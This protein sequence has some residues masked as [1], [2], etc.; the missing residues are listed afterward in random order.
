[1]PK[2]TE[3]MG[4]T[5]R[6]R[7]LLVDGQDAAHRYKAA[8]LEASGHE[9]GTALNGRSAIIA[10]QLFPEVVILDVAL[11]DMTGYELLTAVKHFQ[12]FSKRQVYSPIR[13]RKRLGIQTQ[14]RGCF[15]LFLKK[16]FL[17][18]GVSIFL[19]TL[20]EEK[21]TI[22]QQGAGMQLRL[23]TLALHRLPH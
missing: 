5:A 19:Q 15:R 12:H 18:C 6:S 3:M 10:H 20:R 14:L 9:V 8:W 7:I 23:L 1:M 21:T 2:P 16:P 13:I 22:L 11:P 4:E 17:V